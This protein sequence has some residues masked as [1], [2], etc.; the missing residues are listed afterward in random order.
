MQHKNSSPPKCIEKYQGGFYTYLH[1]H[2]HVYTY[3][4]YIRL[5]TANLASLATPLMQN[6]N[7]TFLKHQNLVDLK[8]SEIDGWKRGEITK[9]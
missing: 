7:Q 2:M 6:L 5:N 1:K 3:M 8:N 4:Y 9:S